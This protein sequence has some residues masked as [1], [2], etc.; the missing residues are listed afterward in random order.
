MKYKID[1]DW[2]PIHVAALEDSIK[3]DPD[4]PPLMA[5][6]VEHG[7]EMND[8]NTR[9]QA[10]RNLGVKEAHFIIWI[11]EQDEYEEFMTRY[12]NYAKEA[13]VIRR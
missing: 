10:Y 7:F 5:H 11:T 4:M 2:W 13:P 9:L 8:G 6:Y 3:K 12:G 1:K